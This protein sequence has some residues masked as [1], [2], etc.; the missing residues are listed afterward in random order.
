MAKHL[1]HRKPHEKAALLPAD[2][3]RF[4][5]QRCAT[6]RANDDTRAKHH[7]PSIEMTKLWH[8]RNRFRRTVKSVHSSPSENRTNKRSIAIAAESVS[9]RS[10]KI[11]TFLMNN[12]INSPRPISHD[13]VGRYITSEGPTEPRPPHE[14]TTKAT[15]LVSKR[16]TGEIP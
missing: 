9:E 10:R 6:R 15:E 7:R 3:N 8:F 12:A 5:L 2:R 1:L 11:R 16:K 4:A 13:F 14:D